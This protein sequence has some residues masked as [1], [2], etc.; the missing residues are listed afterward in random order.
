MFKAKHNFIAI[1]ILGIA[2]AIVIVVM[3]GISWQRAAAPAGKAPIAENIP[4]FAASSTT[5]S[6]LAARTYTPHPPHGSVT[7]QVA[8]AATQLPG[9]LQVTIDPADVHVGQVQHFTVVTNDENPIISVVATI[10][11]D[12]KTI[13]VPLVS[14]GA[15]AVSMLV[16]RTVTVG[17]DGR[18]ALVTAASGTNDPAIATT[19]QGANIANAATAADTTFTGEWTV[20][21]THTAKYQTTFTA[22]DSAGNEN[23]V[24]LQWTDP[25]PFA[26]SNNYAGGTATLS[27]ACDI[28]TGVSGVSSVDGP[29]HGNLSITSGG[30]LTINNGAKLIINSG[31]SLSLSGT[32]SIS[33]PSA[34]AQIVF[35]QDM[36][37]TDSDGDGYTSG[38]NWTAAASCGAM[39][40]RASLAVGGASDCNDGDARAHPGQ[41]AFFSTQEVGTAGSGGAWDFDCN[42]T[43]ASPTPT[44]FTGCKSPTSCGHVD[45]YADGTVMPPVPSCGAFG[46]LYEMSDPNDCGG[47]NG[48]A[49]ADL[50]SGN[51]FYQGCK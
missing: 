33:I 22:K 24:T 44:H 40:P 46:S 36:C 5:S 25:C 45:T 34:G 51:G 1:G 9:F 42:G 28:S 47:T 6:V 48:A 23:S 2:L 18:L 10:V 32:G 26:S 4:P 50:T 43:V 15:P 29:E 37:G 8:Q 7:Y 27:T 19:K 39:V 17:E 12:H 13:T 35:G 38:S 11:T 3:S 14:Q 20:E 16:P 30:S 21:D 41:S 31:Y 49:C